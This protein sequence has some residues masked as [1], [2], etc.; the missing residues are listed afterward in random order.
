M[1]VKHKHMFVHTHKYLVH[2][3]MYV[4]RRVNIHT[5]VYVCIT[6]YYLAVQ[7]RTA[8]TSIESS[9]KYDP[10][11]TVMDALPLS[12]RSSTLPSTRKNMQ[13]AMSPLSKSLS[14]AEACMDT[15]LS[16]NSCT[17]AGLDP[18]IYVKVYI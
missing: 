5:H 17:N 2:V 9:P 6:M 18:D 14:A 7:A 4:Y 13:E 11:S 15:S 12:P 3:S 10:D 16:N 1:K 8:G